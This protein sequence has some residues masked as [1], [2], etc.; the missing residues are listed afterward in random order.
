MRKYESSETKTD[1]QRESDSF[2]TGESDEEGNGET[3]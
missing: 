2:A 3:T 1:R